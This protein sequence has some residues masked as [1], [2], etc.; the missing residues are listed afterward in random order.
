MG[1]VAKGDEFPCEAGLPGHLLWIPFCY[2]KCR[3]SV[4][5]EP[6]RVGDI[7]GIQRRGVP[8][9][10]GRDTEGE[11]FAC[12]ARTGVGMVVLADCSGSMLVP[13]IPVGG[14]PG[15]VLTDWQ[16]CRTRPAAA[17][18][19]CP[20]PK[21]GTTRRV[22]LP[23]GPA[24]G[25]TLP[26]AAAEAQRAPGERRGCLGQRALRQRRQLRGGRPCDPPGPHPVRAAKVHLVGAWRGDEYLAAVADD[27][28]GLAAVLRKPVQR[29]PVCGAP[30]C[31]QNLAPGRDTC[32]AALLGDFVPALCRRHVRVGSSLGKAATEALQSS[33]REG[34]RL[35]G[36]ALKTV[37]DEAS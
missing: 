11:L 36:V 23:Q 7:D 5:E 14:R 26:W 1:A 10:C 15:E 13:V 29:L 32:G 18:G 17:P 3:A 24:V 25:G 27:H 28:H 16:P 8:A 19:R 2:D 22:T 9:E 21:M 6:C 35:S 12:G 37:L 20:P 34:P 30:A 4:G 31:V 33:G